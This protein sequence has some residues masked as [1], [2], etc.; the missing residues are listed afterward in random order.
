MNVLIRAR[1]RRLKLLPASAIDH[2]DHDAIKLCSES[3]HLQGVTV[4]CEYR[5]D[6]QT[7]H[8]HSLRREPS[9]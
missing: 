6:R 3:E 7:L 1:L 5:A 2:P 9:P 4:Q 8:L